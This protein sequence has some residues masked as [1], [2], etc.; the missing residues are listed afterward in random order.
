M[1]LCLCFYYCKQLTEPADRVL[2]VLCDNKCVLQ[3]APH[4]VSP[5]SLTPPA[6]PP[7]LPRPPVEWL[8]GAAPHRHIGWRRRRWGRAAPPSTSTA[9]WAAALPAPTRRCRFHCPTW[10]CRT[11]TPF[12]GGSN[13]RPWQW[14]GCNRER[15]PGLERDILKCEDIWEREDTR[16]K[17]EH[18]RKLSEKKF[19]KFLENLHSVREH[20]DLNC[21]ISHVSQTFTEFKCV[22]LLW[23]QL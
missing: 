16:R 9:R 14:Q 10:R 7:P 5:P 17:W 3:S 2:I 8:V 12:S 19:W 22:T 13:S 23:W 20:L 4:Q 1:Y 21:L 6:L 18:S 15:S 11:P